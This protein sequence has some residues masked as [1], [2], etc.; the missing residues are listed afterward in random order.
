MESVSNIDQI[1]NLKDN[2]FIGKPELVNSSVK[3]NGKNNRHTI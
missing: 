3:F 1:D 2:S